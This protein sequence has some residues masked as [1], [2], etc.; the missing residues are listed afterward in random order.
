MVKK[1]TMYQAAD[2]SVHSTRFAAELTDANVE[3][4]A[5]LSSYFDERTVA[6]AVV[7]AVMAEG[8]RLYEALSTAFGP[9]PIESGDEQ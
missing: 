4:R 6:E 5:A 7:E 9:R 8:P 3:V 1:V 2:G